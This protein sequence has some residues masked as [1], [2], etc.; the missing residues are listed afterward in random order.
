MI[1]H[2]EESEGS[3][4]HDLWKNRSEACFKCFKSLTS[5]N[6]KILKWLMFY[7]F[8]KASNCSSF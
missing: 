1:K 2:Q 8:K 3:N 7:F 4:V 5:E 6:Q